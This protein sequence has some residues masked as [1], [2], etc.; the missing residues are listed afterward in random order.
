MHP[1]KVIREAFKT[2][3]MNATAA[4]DR[5]FATMT[6]PIEVEATLNNEG[7]VIMCFAREESRPE[8]PPTRLDGGQKRTLTIEVQALVTG[9]VNLD[10]K[11]DELAEEIEALFEDWDI[12]AFPAAEIALTETHISTTDGKERFLGGIFMD[13]EVVYWSPYRPRTDQTYEIDDYIP[14]AEVT[15]PGTDFGSDGDGQV[16]DDFVHGAENV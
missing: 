12:P 9:A 5:V 1:R 7:P 4:E 15:L 16:I 13:Y 10:D 14:D 6:P 3:L 11:L 8:L 2:R